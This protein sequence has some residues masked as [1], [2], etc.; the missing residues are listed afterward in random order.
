[1]LRSDLSIEAIAK[2]GGA[3]RYGERAFIQTLWT[4]AVLSEAAAGAGLTVVALYPF[5]DLAR[6]A[7]ELDRKVLFHCRKR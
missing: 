3:S 4:P 7:T 2:D 1:L 6:A 5:N